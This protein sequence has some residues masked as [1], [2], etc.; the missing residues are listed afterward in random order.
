M[1]KDGHKKRWKIEKKNENQMKDNVRPEDSQ[2][3]C[4]FQ[5]PFSVVP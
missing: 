3:C 5:G 1:N 4:P 2:V